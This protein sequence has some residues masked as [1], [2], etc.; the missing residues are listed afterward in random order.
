MGC[1]VLEEADEEE[2]ED[3]A[4]QRECVE[5]SED[6]QIAG[7]RV[8]WGR[9]GISERGLCIKVASERL[10]AVVVVDVTETRDRV[11]NIAFL[12][13]DT[14][15]SEDDGNRRPTARL[16][17]SMFLTVNCE[18]SSLRTLCYNE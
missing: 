8:S 3:V 14:L 7:N 2:E 4:K 10:I 9:R 5:L 18:C 11:V 1:L 12:D 6:M 15:R 16:V 13:S 17:R